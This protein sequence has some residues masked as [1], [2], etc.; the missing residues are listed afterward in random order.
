[1]GVDQ[2]API[3]TASRTL[4]TAIN[5]GFC[6]GSMAIGPNG[7]PWVLCGSSVLVIDSKTDTP[8]A[9][10]ADPEDP[11]AIVF[12]HGDAYVLNDAMPPSIYEIDAA[13][14]KVIHEIP[15]TQ[16]SES[17]WVRL[18]YSPSLKMIYVQG[19]VSGTTG[20]D[21]L[22]LPF[23]PVTNK[24][25]KALDV[26]GMW[27]AQMV[28]APDG[29]TA[30]FFRGVFDAGSV[31]TVDLKTNSVR[32]SPD[33]GLPQDVAF[34]SNGKALYLAFYSEGDNENGF[35]EELSLRSSKVEH[36]WTIRQE[37]GQLY[38]NRFA[39]FVLS[40]G[41]TI[42]S[43]GANNEAFTVI[44]AATHKVLLVKEMGPAPNIG[45]AA[46]G[47]VFDPSGGL[48]W[49]ISRSTTVTPFE[50]RTGRL[51]ASIKVPFEPSILAVG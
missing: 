8:T 47:V 4:G 37:P 2:I 15:F 14:R 51:L 42:N 28:M 41:P 23:D 30:A 11:T 36:R 22:L 18:T 38:V 27:N 21:G 20:F 6:E 12:A 17:P 40:F 1:M 49:L 34:S 26:P 9:T 5:L 44:S 32:V 29:R 10:I 24:F 39:V 43:G 31:T 16:N 7:D 3:R 13:T 46:G 50:V 45:T 48:G 35:L 19:G 25:E 33:L